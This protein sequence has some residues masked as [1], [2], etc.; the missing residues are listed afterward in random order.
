[1][2]ELNYEF[3]DEFKRLDNLCKDIYGSTASS[4]LGV[5]LYLEEME[6]RNYA[7]SLKV[8]GWSS[9]YRK[10][11][12]AR[13]IRNELAHSRNSFSCDICT[14]EDVDF[15]VSFHER[16]LN[17]TDPLATLTKMTSPPQ[18][19]PKITPPPVILTPPPT[20]SAPAPSNGKKSGVDDAAVLKYVLLVCLGLIVIPIIVVIALFVF[21]LF[22]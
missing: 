3:F 16:I 6:R 21:H 7:G 15:V 9:D 19:K 22:S 11:K 12:N 1:M 14:Q 20:N 8:I 2:S 13:N 18:K 10:L 17:R 5:T 4:K